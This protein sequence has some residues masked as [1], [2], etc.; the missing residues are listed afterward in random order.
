[1]ADSE[2]A[3][4]AA[5]PQDLPCLASDIKG[6]KAGI[7]TKNQE[8]HSDYEN[9]SPSQAV[10]W[11]EWAK[12]EIAHLRDLVSTDHLEDPVAIVE[13]VE[14]Q[15]AIQVRSGHQALK[16]LQTLKAMPF[17]T[18]WTTMRHT[19]KTLAVIANGGEIPET[20]LTSAARQEDL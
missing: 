11:V 3:V 16:P 20:S 14:V 19:R 4:E 9:P 2:E 17:P 6:V 10:E 1:M 18:M 15:P 5:Q 7:G 8:I 12:I 13:M